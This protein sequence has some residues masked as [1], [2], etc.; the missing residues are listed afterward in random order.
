MM[1]DN[2]IKIV[3]VVSTFNKDIS[4]KLLDGTIQKFEELG[5]NKQ[6]IE[7]IYVTGAFEIPGVVSQIIDK[8]SLPDAIVTLGS[9]IKGETAHFEYISSSVTH[10]LSMLSIQSSIP[11]IFGVLTTYNYQQALERSDPNKKNKGGEVMSSAI[12]AIDIYQKINQK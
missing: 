6:Y 1:T 10:S 12:D 9:I 5:G 3:I 2:D 7:V 4:D 8:K 11:I